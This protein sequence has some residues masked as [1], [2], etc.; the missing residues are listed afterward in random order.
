IYGSSVEIDDLTLDATSRTT[1]NAGSIEIV[2]GSVRVNI[3]DDGS[4]NL[5][6]LARVRVAST[7][8]G[9]QSGSA[10]TVTIDGDDVR[11]ANA[12]ITVTTESSRTGNTA[13]NISIGRDNSAVTL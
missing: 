7:S 12:D 9:S 13:G 6:P 8:S 4:A 3:S 1:G 10:G 2:G 11:I 5:T